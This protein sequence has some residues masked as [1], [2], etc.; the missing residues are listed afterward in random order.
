MQKWEYKSVLL[1]AQGDAEKFA[2]AGAEGWE[3][4]AVI[5]YGDVG[6]RVFLKRPLK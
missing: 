2:A 5:P 4:Y 3:A 6:A 1:F